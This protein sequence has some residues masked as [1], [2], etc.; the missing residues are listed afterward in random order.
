MRRRAIFHALLPLG[1]AKVALFVLM[2][3]L[4]GLTFLLPDRISPNESPILASIEMHAK[5]LPAIAGTTARSTMAHPAAYAISYAAALFLGLVLGVLFSLAAA[6]MEPLIALARRQSIVARLLWFG[7]ATIL[8]LTFV[9][10]PAIEGQGM[11][12][13]NLLF[14][15]IGSNRLFLLIWVESIFVAVAAVGMWCLFELSNVVRADKTF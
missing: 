6:N 2:A 10:F 3:V 11:R 14:D 5:A 4:G 9:M 15:L 13:V 8:L 1:S 12:S 7:A